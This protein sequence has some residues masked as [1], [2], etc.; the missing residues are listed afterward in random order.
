LPAGAGY[1][2]DTVQQDGLLQTRHHRL[3]EE[4]FDDLARGRPPSLIAARFHAGLADT[5]CSMALQLAGQH[6][7]DTVALSGGVW[8]NGLLL[9]RCMRQLRQAGLEVL[10]HEQLPSNDGCLSLGQAA[11]AAARLHLGT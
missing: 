5:I 11:I 6:H 4:L 1:E 7:S 9:E 8:Q 10:H 3:W 2:L